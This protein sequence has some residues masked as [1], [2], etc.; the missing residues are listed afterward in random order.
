VVAPFL[1][2]CMG[3]EAVPDAGRRRRKMGGGEEGK[4]GRGEKK[5]GKKLSIPL[6]SIPDF[7]QSL[8]VWKEG[9]E[10]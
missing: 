9:G 7:Y 8:I 6:V 1:M 2:N 3:N 5:G 10:R 4:G